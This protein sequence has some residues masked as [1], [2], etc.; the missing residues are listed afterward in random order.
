MKTNIIFLII[1][2]SIILTKKIKRIL[3]NSESEIHLVIK[4]EG[5]QPLMVEFLTYE[6][7]EVW[8][9]GIHRSECSKSCDLSGYKSKVILKF[10]EKI[11]SLSYFFY[12]LKN[13]IEVDL[14]KFHTSLV[15]KLDLMFNE[16]SNLEIVRFGDA[17]LSN[18]KSMMSTFFECTKLIYI[19]LSNFDTLNVERMDNMFNNCESLIYLNLKKFKLTNSVYSNGAFSG[20]PSNAKY[21]IEDTSTKNILSISGTNSD[22]SHKCF[23]ENIKLD[24]VRKECTENCKSSGYEYEYN[25]ICYNECPI[26]SYSIFCDSS[27]CN[28]I[29]KECFDTLPEGYYL[30]SEEKN[31]KKCFEKCKSCFGPGNAT[32]NNCRECQQ[33]LIFLNETLFQSNCYEKCQYY[34]YFDENSKYYCTEND[35]CPDEYN[36]LILEKN[37][38]IDE[39]KKD[40]IYRYEYN[41][42]CFIECPNGTINDESNYICY[43][44]NFENIGSTNL[45]NKNMDSD[46]NTKL[47]TEFNLPYVE[48]NNIFF[49]VQ[50]K[51]NNYNINSTNISNIEIQ[52]EI[53]K[54]IQEILIQG[55]NT[56]DIDKGKDSTFS[57]YNVNYTITSTLNQKNIKNNN[58]TT[59]NLGKCENKLKEEYNISI[60]NSLYILK[61]D[62]V[63]NNIH[64]VEYQIYYPMVNNE[65]NKLNLSKCQNM[66]INISIPVDIPSNEIDNH[67][68][69]SGFYNDICY[70]LTTADG[71]DEPLKDRQNDY[72]NNN[73]SVCEEDCDFTIYDKIKKKAICS[74][75]VKIE[76]PLISEI[77][78]DKNKLLSNF[79]DI[80]N[81]ANFKMLNC[82]HLL[83]NKNNILNNSSNYLFLLLFILNTLTVFIFLF[84]NRIKIK[85]FIDQFSKVNHNDDDDNIINISTANKKVKNTRNKKTKKEKSIKNIKNKNIGN[86]APIKNKD[87]SDQNKIKEIELNTSNTKDKNSKS[88]KFKKSNSKTKKFLNKKNNKSNQ[89]NSNVNFH[90]K[91]KVSNKK[92][93]NELNDLNPNEI[94]NLYN[95]KEMN[96]LDYKE[97]L[98]KDKRTYFQYYL[99]LLRTQHTLAFSFFNIKD[100]NSQIIKIY[101][102]FFT[103]TIDYVISVMFYSDA[104]MHKIYIDEGSFDFTYQL[105][106]MFYSFLISTIFKTIISFLGFYENNI[107]IIKNNIK[108]E[109]TTKKEFNKIKLKVLLFFGIN[110]ILIFLSWIY[111]GC[112]CAVYKNT[113]MHLLLDVSS[114]F[115]ISFVSPF[116][117]YLI[118]GIIRIPSLKNNKRSCLFK[119]STLLQML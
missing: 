39:C 46:I 9:N 12:G 71:T 15:T 79:K 105:P 26:G 86:K 100:Y 3:N 28:E 114:S 94:F 33:E 117:I 98:K 76:L 67:N 40:D 107:I 51:L 65:S 37:K 82:L 42:S 17:N 109:N 56:T 104:T 22:C 66:K 57:F 101:I 88:L 25:N 91:R 118:P 11:T 61:I 90:S 43:S 14:S 59:I 99:S 4:G 55:F 20:V 60:N 45:D 41:D 63:I 112:F 16:C 68:S 30:D 31:Y 62:T 83:F 58:I 64:K 53:L 6:P 18:V 96:E 87:K 74:C 95:E 50:E 32:N 75:F 7:S 27:E 49:I 38:C 81:I 103:F 73:M 54:Y 36:K 35:K 19:D 48:Q 111:L 119:L 10:E 29:T 69:S 108:N 44:E 34:Y 52:D 2:F 5:S 97:A 110:V 78:V 1:I 116:F 93:L 24:T 89:N 23:K 77:K 72:I 47:E 84:Y 8:V 115:A 113:Q 106:Q 80:K 85:K 70:T 102:F 13:I 21:C 92:K